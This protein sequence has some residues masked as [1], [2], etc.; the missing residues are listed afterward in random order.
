[1]SKDKI[2]RLLVRLVLL[3]SIV[4]SAHGALSRAAA[5]PNTEDPALMLPPV[6]DSV[7]VDEPDVDAGEGL[8]FDELVAMMVESLPAGTYTV[9]IHGM[10]TPFELAVENVLVK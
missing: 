5:A 10:T 8:H 6:T 1:M 4:L 9:E 3:A 2:A 7:A